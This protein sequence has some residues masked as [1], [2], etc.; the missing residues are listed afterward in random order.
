MTTTAFRVPKTEV[1]TMCRRIQAI[2]GER[3]ID[4][5]L[6]VQR[7][8]LYYFSGTAQKALLYLPTEGRPTLF[9]RRYY[10]RARDESALE[11]IVSIDTVTALPDLIRDE[12]GRLPQ[13]LGLRLRGERD[14]RR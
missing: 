6:I 10:P 14:R 8:D 5:L 3:G 13:V 4:G 1:E 11:A 12:Y 7:V 2:L 9:V